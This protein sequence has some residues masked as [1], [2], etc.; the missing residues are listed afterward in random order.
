[1][2]AWEFEVATEQLQFNFGVQLELCYGAWTAGSGSKGRYRKGV[3]EKKGKSRQRNESAA[4]AFVTH[5]TGQKRPL[6]E[7]QTHADV[8]ARPVK[9][10]TLARGS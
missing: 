7:S 4:Y 8:R 9:M 5:D 6:C 1:M 10:K 2:G 3:S